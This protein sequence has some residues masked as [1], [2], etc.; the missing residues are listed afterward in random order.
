MFF[1]FHPD[2]VPASRAALAM[3][4]LALPY[5]VNALTFTDA[6]ALA[7]RVAPSLSANETR[8]DAARQAAIPAGALPDPKLSLGVNNLPVQGNNSFSLSSDF[9][10]MQHI[11]VMQAFPNSAKL[12]ARVAAAAGR[13]ALA[14]AQTRLLRLQV[15]KQTA[16]AWI[17]RQT[18]ESQLALIADLANENRLF[19]RAVQSRFSGGAGMSSELIAPRREA[20]LIEERRDELASRQA[21]AIA[22]LKRWIGEAG[23]QPLTGTVPDWPINQHSLSH[24][25]HRHPEL[26]LFDPKTQV[27]DAEV[28][29]AKAAKIPDWALEVGYQR[30]GP[31]FSDMMSVQVSIDLPLFSGSRQQPKLE[32]KLLERNALIAERNAALLEHTAMLES[33][34]AEHL[35]LSNAVKRARETLIP[36]AEQ[37]VALA[38][39][40]WRGNRG[41]LTTLSAARQDRIDTELKA[42]ALEGERLQLAAHLH[43]TYS[44]QTLEHAELR[45]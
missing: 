35:R 20:A 2:L 41:E 23:A 22:Q 18:V 11:G 24:G 38:L 25:L 1:L 43:Y 14:E 15:L 19:D 34:L 7:L 32:A 30:R 31:E 37:K 39:A 3:L 44:E 5:N 12:D 4:F 13:V 21:Q 6:Q 9:M 26:D 16:A 45:P 36:L 33:A 42:I 8:I 17:A 27:L 29:E 10:T 28:A 40:D